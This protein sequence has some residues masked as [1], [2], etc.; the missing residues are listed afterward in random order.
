MAKR[1][2]HT[3]TLTFTAMRSVKAH[4]LMFIEKW[5]HF[6]FR[7]RNI[8]YKLLLEDPYLTHMKSQ[9]SQSYQFPLITLENHQ[10]KSIEIELP[11]FPF[12]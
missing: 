1:M 5:L 12:P 6:T 8:D 2:S 3:K 9:K 7:V 4:P 11:L 10:V